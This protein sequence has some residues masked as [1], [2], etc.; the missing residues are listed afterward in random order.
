MLFVIGLTACKKEGTELFW[1]NTTL[2]KRLADT[3][4]ARQNTLVSAPNGWT[5]IFK[6]KGGGTY[7]FYFK[8]YDNNRVD[9]VSDINIDVASNVANS[10]YVF[11]VTGQPSLIFDTYSPLHILSHPQNSTSGGTEAQGKISDYE[12]YFKTITKDEVVLQGVKN[13]NTMVLK[14]ATQVEEEFYRSGGIGAAM[15][16]II[17]RIKRITDEATAAMGNKFLR[18]EEGN[19]Q[20]P[21]SIDLIA[22]KVSLTNID[23]NNQTTNQSVSFE[24]STDADEL[25][26][27]SPLIYNGKSYTKIYW[28]AT[29]KEFYLLDG[30]TRHIFKTSDTPTTLDFTPP[31]HEMFGLNGYKIMKVNPARVPQTGKFKEVL[32][33][34]LQTVANANR[35]YTYF[36]LNL[37]PNVNVAGAD[38]TL[39]VRTVGG[40]VFF[41]GSYYYK[42]IWVDKPNGIFTL[43]H[44]GNAG[45]YAASTLS[46]SANLRNYLTSHTFKAAYLAVSRTDNLPVGGFISTNEPNSFISGVL[47]NAVGDLP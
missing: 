46:Y 44:S 47:G 22:K 12:F 9:M 6:P 8:F 24:F 45:S 21:A 35:T 20:T 10:S 25:N 13:G 29:N 3:I 7:L 41:I 33:L 43:Q 27:V 34:D 32:D 28:D 36:S 30:T 23:A 39:S 16:D 5:T 37:E 26:L 40:N 18:I 11:R 17:A 42:I 19:K 38:I 15:A 14:R 4:A 1:G 31:F 2:D